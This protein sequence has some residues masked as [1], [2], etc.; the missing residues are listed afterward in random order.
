MA[1]ADAIFT[2]K[3]IPISEKR[4]SM[5]FSQCAGLDSHPRVT[6]VEVLA[7][8][9]MFSPTIVKRPY[10]GPPYAQRRCAAIV[11]AVVELSVLRHVT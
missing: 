4:G 7:P 3:A 6:S 9:A 1:S 10:P 5:M 11:A 8:A 2:A